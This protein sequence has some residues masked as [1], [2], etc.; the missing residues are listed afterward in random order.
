MSSCVIFEK[1]IQ[2]LGKKLMKDF[3][4][5]MND[6]LLLEQAEEYKLQRKFYDENLVKE[7]LK[8]YKKENTELYLPYLNML[9]T[10][11]LEKM[12]QDEISKKIHDLL[13]NDLLT[14]EHSEL[15]KKLE[16]LIKDEA[17]PTT[18]IFNFFDEMDDKLG[19]DPMIEFELGEDFY[20][21]K[22]AFLNI[23]NV[24]YYDYKEI[25]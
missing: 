12:E 22:K 21:M 9:N 2:K 19:I 3:Y 8:F 23:Y 13:Q 18:V 5:Q 17:L 15:F 11:K 24:F 14:M 10:K 20:H 6:K 16:E 25:I 1:D 4:L 7:F